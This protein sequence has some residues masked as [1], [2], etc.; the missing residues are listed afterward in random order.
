[1]IAER[2][3]SCVQFIIKYFVHKVHRKKAEKIKEGELISIY[4]NAYISIIT[5]SKNIIFYKH[6]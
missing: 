3:S 5:C 2:N 4:R 1:M 6:A